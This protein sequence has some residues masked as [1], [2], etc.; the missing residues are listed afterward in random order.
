TIDALV[1]AQEA[2]ADDALA[3]V[4]RRKIASCDAELARYRAA[5]DAGADPV[6]VAQR[7]NT[8]TAER[9]PA[10][11]ET[12][13]ASRLRRLTPEEIAEMVDGIADRSEVVAVADPKDKAELYEKMGLPL[14]YPRE[15]PT[16]EARIEPHLHR[17]CQRLVSEGG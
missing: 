6:T 3:D 12:P 2:E 14:T 15:T 5:L 4:A 7:I 17:R 9:V 1:Q 16:V 11:R 13:G 10:E 8:A